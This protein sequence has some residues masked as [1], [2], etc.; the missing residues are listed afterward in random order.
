[1]THGGTVP[2]SHGTNRHDANGMEKRQTKYYTTHEVSDT[3][4]VT[5]MTHRGQDT[6]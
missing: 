4:W 6:L 3:L 2:M 1:M 5:H